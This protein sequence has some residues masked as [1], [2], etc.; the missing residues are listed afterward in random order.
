MP[1][2]RESFCIVSHLHI[3][4][5]LWS[6]ETIGSS[7]GPDWLDK[8]PDIRKSP[9]REWPLWSPTVFCGS[10]Y[11]WSHKAS[12]FCEQIKLCY[13]LG[14]IVSLSTQ[15]KPQSHERPHENPNHILQKERTQPKRSVSTT[16]HSRKVSYGDNQRSE[17]ARGHCRER[18]V[19]GPGGLG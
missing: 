4:M 1:H 14:Y 7:L 15:E 2:Q 10:S 17:A 3:N 5:A 16:E 9:P 12:V 18:N 19:R 6:G 8:W 11:E 13:E